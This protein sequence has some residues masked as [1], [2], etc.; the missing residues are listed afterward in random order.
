M[1][2]QP[3][4]QPMV[5]EPMY[6]EQPQMTRQEWPQMIQQQPPPSPVQLSK[7]PSNSIWPEKLAK[8]APADDKPSRKKGQNRDSEYSDEYV[9]ENQA[10]GDDVTTTEAPK[11]VRKHLTRPQLPFSNF[12][13]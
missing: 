1:M 8:P 11:K 5:E 7:E 9:D 6:R 12:H 4:Q 3:G 10:E 2:P 13:L